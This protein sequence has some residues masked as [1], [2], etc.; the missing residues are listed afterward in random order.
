LAD[1][2]AAA[3]RCTA[4][5]AVQY[6]LPSVVNHP[7][8]TEVLKGVAA[9]IVGAEKVEESPLLMLSEDFSFYLEKVPGVFFFL[10]TGDAGKGTDFPHHSSRF[11]IDDAVLP[12]GISLVSAFAL[13]MLEKLREGRSS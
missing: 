8:P 4:E 11:N 7:V 13:N 10:G 5:V 3:Y 6:I 9:K 12:T 1:G 2:I